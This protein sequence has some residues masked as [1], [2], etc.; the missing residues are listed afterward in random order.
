MVCSVVH[1]GLAA[2]VFC[3]L[4]SGGCRPNEREIPVERVSC[5]LYADGKKV[6]GGVLI[7]TVK[8]GV[9]N[10]ALL[11][12]RH[13]VTANRDYLRNLSATFPLDTGGD[14]RIVLRGDTR[15][16]WLTVPSEAFDC[17]W[18][19]LN[20]DEMPAGTE[21][22]DAGY[23]MATAGQAIEK[24]C[25][26]S[27]PLSA[28]GGVFRYIDSG[29]IPDFPFEHNLRMRKAALEVSTVFG[30]TEVGESGGPVFVC[31]VEGK[32]VRLAGT[33]VGSNRDVWQT[34]FTEITNVIDEVCAALSGGAA[35]RLADCPALW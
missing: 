6:G 32:A 17:A 5:A 7:G 33:T 9:T 22:V 28:S 26:M 14:R 35:R 20:G 10:V 2:S 11:T 34:V 19:L 4:V 23:V 1:I 27:I 30:I 15:P 13:V 18:I 31:D 16:R 8:G 21:W 29:R 24:G 12:A 25:P 3:G